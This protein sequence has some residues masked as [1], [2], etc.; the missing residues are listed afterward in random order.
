[1]KNKGRPFLEKLDAKETSLWSEALCIDYGGAFLDQARIW[2]GTVMA[3]IFVGRQPQDV[4]WDEFKAEFE[5]KYLPLMSGRGKKG[6]S[7]H[8]DRDP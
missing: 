4:T 6:I 7:R 5:G 8:L 3:S 2:W 1:M